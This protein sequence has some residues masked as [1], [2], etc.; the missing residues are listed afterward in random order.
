LFTKK[1]NRNKKK[2]SKRDRPPNFFEDEDDED[3]LIAAS[4]ENDKEQE[5]DMVGF[6]EYMNSKTSKPGKYGFTV[7]KLR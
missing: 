5:N 4:L 2:M 1:L 7:E 3:Y 6:E